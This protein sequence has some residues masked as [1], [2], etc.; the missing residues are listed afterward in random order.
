MQTSSIIKPLFI[1]LSIKK[2]V[3]LFLYH[4]NPTSIYIYDKISNIKN[5][6]K[7]KTL[8]NHSKCWY[9]LNL[10]PWL[11]RTYT[12]WSLSNFFSFT[13]THCSPP[14]PWISW[15]SAD[16][17]PPVSSELKGMFCP[18]AFPRQTTSHF[19]GSPFKCP[20]LTINVA[21]SMSFL[22]HSGFHSLN[23]IC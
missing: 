17:F 21:P 18:W 5:D 3:K 19:S 4:L 15:S 12:I 13:L 14:W 8:R 22:C 6:K 9:D 23:S 10:V 2:L 1:S 16:V 20:S 7:E 11:A